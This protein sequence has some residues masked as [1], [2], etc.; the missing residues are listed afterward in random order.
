MNQISEIHGRLDA[1][2]STAESN[3]ALERTVAELLD[4]LEATRKTLQSS[5]SAL[6]DGAPASGDIAEL[7]AEQANSDRRMQTRLADVQ[8]IL[9]RL[10][11]RLG[12]IEDEVGRDD[13]EDEPAPQRSAPTFAA[14]PPMRDARRQHRGQRRRV[15][16]HSRPN[17]APRGSRRDRREPSR[18][19][20][21]LARRSEFS[22]RARTS[23]AANAGRGD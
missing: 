13:A 10:V 23:A 4:E 19:R 9:E 15:P 21:E 14:R 7:R 6:N 1:L 12:R 22:S 17:S 18:R 3:A 2:N 5:A 16:Q 20:R 8:D 11:G